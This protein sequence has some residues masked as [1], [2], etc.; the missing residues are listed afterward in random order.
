M[1][2]MYFALHVN[3]QRLY[4]LGLLKSN[5]LSVSTKCWG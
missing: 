2:Y 4:L 3:S 5:E 1:Y